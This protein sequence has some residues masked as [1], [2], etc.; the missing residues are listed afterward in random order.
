MRPLKAGGAGIWGRLKACRKYSEILTPDGLPPLPEEA[1]RLLHHAGAQR[2]RAHPAGN[3]DDPSQ[4]YDGDKE[5]V[6]AL[7]PSTDDTNAIIEQTAAADPRIETV[8][9]L[10]AVTPIGLNL[11]FARPVTRSSSAST[12][13]PASTLNTCSRP[14]TPCARPEPRTAAD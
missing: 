5:V 14:S 1:R 11:A 8:D 3:H 2:G 13:T 10:Q 12:C 7:G 4:D 9:N 6:L